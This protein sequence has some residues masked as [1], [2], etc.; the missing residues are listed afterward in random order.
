[1]G[2]REII[3][4]QSPKSV[5]SSTFSPKQLRYL[6]SPNSV[7]MGS[8]NNGNSVSPRSLESGYSIASSEDES[9]HN[10]VNT[11]SDSESSMSVSSRSLS[12]ISRS[13]NKRRENGIHCVLPSHESGNKTKQ[14]PKSAPASKTKKK[15][16]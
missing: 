15:G 11:M 13:Y 3:S 16:Y 8:L 7:K 6:S 9:C 5:T 14:S 4:Q 12:R 1:M 10:S 2:K